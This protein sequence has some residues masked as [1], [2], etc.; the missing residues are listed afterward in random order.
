MKEDLKDMEDTNRILENNLSKKSGNV[1]IELKNKLGEIDS[2][3]EDVRN[4]ESLLGELKTTIRKKDSD[5]KGFNLDSIE[6][7][8]QIGKLTEQKT[9]LK[10][11]VAKL[12]AVQVELKSDQIKLQGDVERLRHDGEGKQKDISDWKMRTERLEYDLEAAHAKLN[13]TTEGHRIRIKGEMEREF[14]VQILEL[15]KVIGGQKLELG[16]LQEEVGRKMKEI[17]ELRAK[18]KYKNTQLIEFNKFLM[19]SIKKNKKEKENQGV[20]EDEDLTVNLIKTK[21]QPDLN[22][23][24]A[25]DVASLINQNKSILKELVKFKTMYE[26]LKEDYD[27]LKNSYEDS[28]YKKERMSKELIDT[29]NVYNEFREQNMF[30][31]RELDRQENSVKSLKEDLKYSENQIENAK[32]ENDELYKIIKGIR[33]GEF[34]SNDVLNKMK[35]N[36]ESKINENRQ[37]IEALDLRE[38]QIQK[39]EEKVEEQQISMSAVIDMSQYNTNQK[40]EKNKDFSELIPLSKA[41]VV[42][43]SVAI[44]MQKTIDQIREHNRDMKRLL[45]AKSLDLERKEASLKR[46]KQELE[47]LQRLYRE[48]NQSNTTMDKDVEGLNTLL[49]QRTN[50]IETLEEQVDILKEKSRENKEKIRLFEQE[51]LGLRG[52]NTEKETVVLHLENEVKKLKEHIQDLETPA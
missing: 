29:K 44:S 27:H 34:D 37:L 18:L 45:E 24:R 25:D 31:K 21:N 8:K 11:L 51:N 16:S 30:Y 4:K 36:I 13:E 50:E 23:E 6:A 7:Q 1:G 47:T 46:T 2:L 39:L 5:I 3:R 33:G 10:G 22:A 15:E 41:L 19:E 20:P 28:R 12:E 9:E 14:G 35:N 32:K 40:P 48:G 26:L 42:D 17:Q 38:K 52:D 43:E 49:V